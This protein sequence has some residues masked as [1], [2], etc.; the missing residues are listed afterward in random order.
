MKISNSDW[1]ELVSFS[2]IELDSLAKLKAPTEN[3]FYDGA[4]IA[5]LK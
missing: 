1:K 5:S 4:A 2:K 3:V